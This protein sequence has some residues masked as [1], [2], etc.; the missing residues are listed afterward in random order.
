M[1]AEPKKV[2]TLEEYLALERE[3]EIRH[4]YLNGEILDMSGGTLNHDLTMGNVFDLMRQ[5]LL[6]K[7]CQVFTA[8]M[9]I[10][11]PAL[12]PYRYADGSV[13]CGGVEVEQFNGCD[14]L[15]NPVLVWEVLSKNTEAYD[16]GDKFTYYKSIPSLK[17]YLL[18]AQHRPHVTHYTKQNERIWYRE[19]FN[20]RNESVYLPS[21]EVTLQLSEIYQD[22]I[23]PA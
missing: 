20:D 23:F 19:E 12:L 21:L 4:E 7:T 11:T 13:V 10:K 17:E 14:L 16:R 2:Y 22:V 18:I 3:S 1:S 6:G 5:R 9:Q 15:L 8:N